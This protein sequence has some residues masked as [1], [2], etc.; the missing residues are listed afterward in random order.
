MTGS[1]HTAVLGDSTPT[2]LGGRAVPVPGPVL[3]L[4][5][6]AEHC[7]LSRDQVVSEIPG[8]VLMAPSG[9]ARGLVYMPKLTYANASAKL[10]AVLDAHPDIRWIQLPMAGVDFY[11]DLMKKPN[12]RDRIWTSGKV[13][14]Q[15][16]GIVRRL[17][18][19]LTIGME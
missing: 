15:P 6:E 12:M 13:R 10:E 9:R 7:T 14:L 19:L 1:Q 16:E 17:Y 11:S 8:E 2:S 3:I 5:A 4:P 18:A